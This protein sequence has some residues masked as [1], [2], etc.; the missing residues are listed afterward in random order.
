MKNTIKLI[1]VFALKFIVIIAQG[2]YLFI[3]FATFHLYQ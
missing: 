2:I 1:I 3:Y